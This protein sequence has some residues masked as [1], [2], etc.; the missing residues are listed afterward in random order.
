MAQPTDKGR[1]EGDGGAR[2]DEAPERAHASIGQW[3]TSGARTPSEASARGLE[4]RHHGAAAIRGLDCPRSRYSDS[5]RFGRLVP[6]LPTLY[7][8]REDL[9]AL[10]AAG[11][12]MDPQD[13][14]PPATGTGNPDNPADLAAGF[15]FLGQFID[16]DITFDP[17][18]SLERQVDPEAVSN[19]RTPTLELDSVYGAGP[20]ASPHL[21]QRAD[22][23][24]LLIG[25]DAGGGDNDLPR[26]AESVALLGDPRN[27]ENLIVS[28]LHLA[29]LKFHNAVVDRV[30]GE[31]VAPR[32]VF[33]EA[34]R[35]VRWHYQWMIVHE[36]LPHI[37]G[38]PM[39]DAVL[40]KGRRYYN[41][42]NEPYIPV[43]F[44]VAAYRFGHSQ[45]RPA[46]RINGG[47]A[48]PIFAA[49]TTTGAEGLPNDLSG[50]RQIRP[51]QV[52]DWTGLFAVDG[53][54]PQPGKAID[55][56]ISSPL[57]NL[58]FASGAPEDPKSLAT[59]NLLRHV[60][61]GL[62]AGQ[63]VAWAMRE[64]PLRPNELRGV[65][66]LGFDRY[67]PLWYYIL[68][69]AELR[70]SG[71][72]LGPVGGRIVCEVLVGL[73]EGDR[74]SYLRA[75]PRWKPDLGTRGRFG[76]AELLKVAGV[77]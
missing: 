24:K 37:V 70:A 40:E 10:G 38:R 68:K 21:Y 33:R 25:K 74:L 15:T 32:D 77:V 46:Y 66:D 3:P 60:T 8:E 36:F 34:Q 27:D 48:R 59:R 50:G 35:R 7:A 17:T 63:D 52:V 12:P 53:S 22:P 23:D 44:S 67:T 45:V 49:E 5:A 31:G 26:N 16:H 11:G 56:R 6:T 75:G 54:R 19:F 39:V 62:P 55:T 51:E 64:E 43:E 20:G 2:P 13:R 73:L 69:E 9:S 65:R 42:R 41:W 29:F 58:P 28:Q 72:H 76:M 71:A 47:F 14:P 1:N 4:M 61:F 18:S 57:L 30:R